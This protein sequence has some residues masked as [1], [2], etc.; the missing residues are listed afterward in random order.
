MKVLLKSRDI[1]LCDGRLSYSLAA[2][3]MRSRWH[4]GR[5]QSQEVMHA[6]QFECVQFYTMLQPRQTRHSGVPSSIAL[7]SLRRSPCP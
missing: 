2:D 5:R 3:L 1:A 6:F 4:A 7:G